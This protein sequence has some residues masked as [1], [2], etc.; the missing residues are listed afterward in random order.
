MLPVVTL[1][2]DPS[3]TCS[4]IAKAVFKVAVLK[5][6]VMVRLVEQLLISWSV[7]ISSM[8]HTI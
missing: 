8:Q 5:P 3:M 6:I 4:P 7:D 2:H 1:S